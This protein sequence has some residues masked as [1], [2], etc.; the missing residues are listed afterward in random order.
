MSTQVSIFNTHY[1]KAPSSSISVLEYLGS[2]EHGKWKDITEAARLALATYGKG[3]EYKTAKEKAPFITLSAEF[4]GRRQKDAPQKHSGFILMDVDA[5]DNNLEDIDAFG[6]RAFLDDYIYAHHK[7]IG[8]EGIAIIVKIDGDNHLKSFL[9]LEQY[10][11][12][13][14]K[15]VVDKGCKDITRGRYGSYDPELVSNLTSEVFEGEILEKYL[16]EVTERKPSKR[17]EDT[18]APELKNIQEIAA[19]MVANNPQVVDTYEDFIRMGFALVSAFGESGRG[20]FHTLCE[21]HPSYKQSEADRQYTNCV[22]TYDGS[23]T[24]GTFYHFAK[25]C[26]VRVIGQK[27]VERPKGAS[28]KDTLA[29]IKKFCDTAEKKPNLD[30]SFKL[31][32]D[33]VDSMH[34][35][36]NEITN[37]VE[38]NGNPIPDKFEKIIA[39]K[40]RTVMPPSCVRV[41]TIEEIVDGITDSYNPIKDYLEEIGNK[42]SQGQLDSLLDSIVLGE[43]S[44]EELK[45]MIKK[46]LVSI[47]ATVYGKKPELVLVLSGSQGCGKSTFFENLLPKQLSSYL[48]TGEFKDDKDFL[49]KMSQKLLLINDE[50]SGFKHADW[51]KF[52]A[53]VSTSVINER[54]AYGRRAQDFVRLGV[55]GGATNEMTFMSDDTGNRRIIPTNMKKLKYEQY[56][57]IDKEGLFSELVAEFVADEEWSWRLT[58]EEQQFIKEASDANRFKFDDEVLIE[59]TFKPLDKFSKEQNVYFLTATDTLKVLGILNPN[60][61]KYQSTHI[62]QTMTRLGFESVSKRMGGSPK[63]GYYVEVKGDTLRM[64]SGTY[65]FNS[66]DHKVDLP[67]NF[68]GGEQQNIGL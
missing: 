19:Q 35:I 17:R 1:A 27:K 48:A 63:K 50:M 15:L 3:D 12:K 8:G 16:P 53:L 58:P 34:L 24:M 43:D 40:L 60:L 66:V 62:G 2:V 18:P 65:G 14:Y 23:T 10:F 9:A 46:W 4:E 54:V 5:Q 21:G 6:E 59:E 57:D 55:F 45:Q 29:Y 31:T 13:E 41:R 36:I 51:K 38:Y 56:L 39:A 47:V 28:P 42:P 11:L 30:V 25:V 22:D 64:I 67:I 61:K 37:R 44:S 52:K 68:K 26:G 20:V 33:F 49:I 32:K 7:S